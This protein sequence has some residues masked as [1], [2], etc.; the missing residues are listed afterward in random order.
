MSRLRI[1]MCLCLLPQY[2]SKA[3]YEALFLG[4]VH[5]EP[6]NRIWKP[7]APAKCKF[8]IWLTALNKCWTADRLSK[9][10]LPHPIRCPLCD[11]QQETID[12]LLVNCVFAREF[13]FHVLSKVNLQSLSPQLHNRGFMVW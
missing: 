11:Q 6:A 1:G 12:H 9:R 3:V 7:W 10:G 13:W 8:F 5:F 2:S 4:S